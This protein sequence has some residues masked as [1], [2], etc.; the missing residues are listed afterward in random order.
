[1]TH[2][3]SLG[4]E[5]NKFLIGGGFCI[6]RF[7]IRDIQS[8]YN[9]CEHSNEETKAELEER[10]HLSHFSYYRCKDID[11]QSR[12]LSSLWCYTKDKLQ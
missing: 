8:V 9:L 4:M 5:I 1:M 7:W 11:F 3:L 12:K 10:S 2:Y 6:I